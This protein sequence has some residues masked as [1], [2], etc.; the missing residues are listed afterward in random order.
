MTVDG[1]IGVRKFFCDNPACTRKIFTERLPG[2]VARSAR[3]TLR[4]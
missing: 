3:R 2:L 4:L 1:R